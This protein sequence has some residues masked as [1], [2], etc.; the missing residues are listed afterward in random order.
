MAP[1][2]K[3]AAPAAAKEGDDKKEEAPKPD[4]WKSI[5]NIAYYYLRFVT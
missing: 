2:P 3:P 4:A 5:W 1:E